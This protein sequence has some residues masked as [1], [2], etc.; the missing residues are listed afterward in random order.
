MRLDH[1]SDNHR[2]ELITYRP[3][4]VEWFLAD[5]NNGRAYAIRPS[6]RLPVVCDIM[7]CS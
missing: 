3:R 2:A 5:H 4:L 6:V 7:Y 1:W